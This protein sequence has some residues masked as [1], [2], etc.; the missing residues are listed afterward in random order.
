MCVRVCG[1]CV[2]ITL[3][4]VLITIENLGNAKVVKKDTDTQL[5]RNVV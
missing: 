4:F 5:R 2:V 3:D 1:R